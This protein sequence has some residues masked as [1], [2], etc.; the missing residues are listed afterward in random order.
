[1]GFRAFCEIQV[2][3]EG[4]SKIQGKPTSVSGGFT[5]AFRVVSGGFSRFQRFMKISKG[6]KKCQCASGCIR[7]FQRISIELCIPSNLHCPAVVLWK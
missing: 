7:R 5:K 2:V 6:F 1:M 4:F 3:S